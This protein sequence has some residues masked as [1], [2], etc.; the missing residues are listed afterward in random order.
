[1]QQNRPKLPFDGDYDFGQAWLVIREWRYSDTVPYM[2]R[3]AMEYFAPRLAFWIS[4]AK[5]SA[6]RKLF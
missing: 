4:V 5:R 3:K 6:K 1:M 2:K